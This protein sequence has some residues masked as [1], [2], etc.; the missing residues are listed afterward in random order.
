MDDEDLF[1]SALVVGEIRRGIEKACHRQTEKAEALELWLLEVVVG[2][3]HRILPVDPRVAQ[4]WGRLSARR[5][6]PVIDG[7][8]AATAKIHGLVLVTRNVADV[9]STGCWWLDPFRPE[10]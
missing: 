10:V 9:R 4:E 2:F 7:L 8:L 1:L 5:T 6:V 3:G